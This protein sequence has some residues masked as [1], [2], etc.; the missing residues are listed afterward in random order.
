MTEIVANGTSRM[1]TYGA[2]IA[3]RY[4]NFGNIVWMMGGDAGTGTNPFDS[5]QTAVEAALLAGLKSVAGQQSVQFSAEW[6][7]ASIVTDQ[8][9]FGEDM[10]LNGTYSSSGMDIVT[11]GRRAHGHTPLR[12]AYQ[13]EQP[14]DEE[15]NDGNGVNP[16][17]TQPTRRFQW[18]GWLSTIGGYLFGNGYVW[19]FRAPAWKDHLNSAGT[20]DMAQLNAFVRSIPWYQLAPSG[21]GG[22]KNLITSGGGTGTDLVAAVANPAGTHLVAYVPPDRRGMPFTIDMTAMSGMTR[23]RWFN[24][25]SGAYT[26]IA[27]YPNTGTQSFTPPGNNGS[28]YDDW[29]LL[30]DRAP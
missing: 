11:L 23:A 12:P 16:N 5:T 28:G 24:P 30:L 9:T 29:V 4:K 21:L 10:T 20:R 18:W 7:F 1:M 19:P 15:G 26:A 8:V 3:N 14:F 13:Q 17:A 27:N 25:S 6:Q 2:F 22:V